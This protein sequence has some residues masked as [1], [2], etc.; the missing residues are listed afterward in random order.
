LEL[1][2]LNVFLFSLRFYDVGFKPPTLD[3]PPKDFTAQSL[4]MTTTMS[5]GLPNPGMPSTGMPAA[6]IPTAMPNITRGTP[7]LGALSS[8][9]TLKQQQS[10]DQLRQPR[11]EHILCFN[12]IKC[13]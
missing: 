10:V 3:Y 4:S 2:P 9:V 12:N 5:T 8:Q 13:Y 1:L 11:G 7:T 6:A